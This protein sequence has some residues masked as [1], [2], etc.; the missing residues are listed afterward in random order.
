MTF[1]ANS[2]VVRLRTGKMAPLD[3]PMIL[4]TRRPSGGWWAKFRINGVDQIFKGRFPAETFKL[5]QE[6]HKKNNITLRPQDIWLNLILQWMERLDLKYF[7]VNRVDLTN[8]IQGQE[9]G[10]RATQRQAVLPQVWGSIAWKWLGL[11]L[12]QDS[13]SSETFLSNLDQVLNLMSPSSNPSLGCLE[14]FTEFSTELHRIRLNMPPDR[15][16]A[17]QWLWNFHNKVNRRIHKPVI[18]FERA[19]RLNFWL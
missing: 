18:P 13:Y 5:V 14:C 7:L 8:M 19:A 16:A 2:P 12:A 9:T 3:N 1:I 11:L 4:G 6:G 17:R 10:P 15:D